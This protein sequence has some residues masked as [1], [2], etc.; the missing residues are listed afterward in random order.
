MSLQAIALPGTADY[1]QLAAEGGRPQSDPVTSEIPV[2]LVPV[3]R[4]AERVPSQFGGFAVLVAGV[5]NNV[6]PH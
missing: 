6:S 1:R 5:D 3:H 4:S 2:P